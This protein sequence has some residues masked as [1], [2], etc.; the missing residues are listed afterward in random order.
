MRTGTALEGGA[1]A[2]SSS[3][4]SSSDSSLGGLGIKYFDSL[5]LFGFGDATFFFFGSFSLASLAAASSAFRAF[6]LFSASC[7]AANL[8]FSASSSANLLSLLLCPAALL[9]PA[10]ASSPPLRLPCLASSLATAAVFS[11]TKA[12][13]FFATEKGSSLAISAAFFSGFRLKPVLTDP[14]FFGRSAA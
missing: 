13:L 14:C 8:F 7:R 2:T 6:L 12:A 10:A 3:S 4:S 11:A 1:K 5:F 9:S